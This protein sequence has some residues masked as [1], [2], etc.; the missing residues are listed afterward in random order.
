VNIDQCPYILSLDDPFTPTEVEKAV[1]TCKN[2]VY[3]GVATGLFR[4]IPVFM[5]IYVIRI[6]NIIF[7]NTQYPVLWTYGKL[8]TLF[9]S[10]S[11]MIC[12]NY[13]G[14]IE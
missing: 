10:G 5:L 4:Y 8:T 6:L 11:R 3:V 7:C 14:L 13:R 9:K 2:N 1:Y 12:G